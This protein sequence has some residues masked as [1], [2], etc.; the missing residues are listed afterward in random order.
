MAI[1]NGVTDAGID[2]FYGTYDD[3][4]ALAEDPQP[5]DFCVNCGPLPEGERECPCMAAHIDSLEKAHAAAEMASVARPM[6][7][8]PFD[9]EDDIP[10]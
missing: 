3:Y 7:G 5:G 8:R 2:A 6:F 9:P 4:L 1:G 10:F